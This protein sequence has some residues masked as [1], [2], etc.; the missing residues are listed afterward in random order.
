MGFAGGSVVKNLPGHAGDAGDLGSTPGSGRSPGRENGNL[1]QYSFLD[2]PMDRRAWPA[3]VHGVT[4]SWTQLSELNNCYVPDNM[5]G[6]LF[7]LAVE[8]HAPVTELHPS[9]WHIMLS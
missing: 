6:T 3:A 7:K 4:K 1:L 2:N 8:P 9:Q 5:T